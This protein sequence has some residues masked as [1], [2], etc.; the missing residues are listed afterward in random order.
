ME[1]DETQVLQAFAAYVGTFD[2]TDAAV[3]LK[4]GHSLRVSVLCRRISRSLGLPPEDQNLAWCLGV[5]HDVGRFEQLRQYDTFIDYRSMDHAR[6]GVHYLFEE[7]HIRDFLTPAD[8]DDLL[9]VAIG[10]HNMYRLRPDLTARQRLFCQILR[11]A[12]KID[13]FRVYAEHVKDIHT[14]ND[15]ERNAPAQQVLSPAV[16]AEARQERTIPTAYKKTFIDFYVGMLCLYFELVY[17]VSRQIADAQGYYGRLLA[18][19]S[20]N[21]ETEAF[22]AEMRAGVENYRRRRV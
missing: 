19:H 14:F 9:S 5:L 10:Q 3:R 6:Y 15:D 22:L 21:P 8:E 7:G 1:I 2:T 13:I 16:L 18:A 17:P 20:D 12:D 4:Y 11:D